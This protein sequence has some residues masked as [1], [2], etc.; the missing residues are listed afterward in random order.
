MQPR[1]TDGCASCEL[2]NSREH[3]AAH[4][5]SCAVH[6]L[7]SCAYHPCGYWKCWGTMKGFGAGERRYQSWGHMDY[8]ARIPCIQTPISLGWSPLW[9]L[10]QLKH[11]KCSLSLIALVFLR[12]AGAGPICQGPCY[13]LGP[14]NSRSSLITQQLRRKARRRNPA[15]LLIFTLF[16]MEAEVASVRSEVIFRTV[17]LHHQLLGSASLFEKWKGLLPFFLCLLEKQVREKNIVMISQ[18]MHR[19]SSIPIIIIKHQE[20]MN[21]VRRPYRA[22]LKPLA[23]LKIFPDI[24]LTT[25]QMAKFEL[26]QQFADLSP[27][28]V[29]FISKPSPQTPYFVRLY[30]LNCI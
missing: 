16:L 18:G 8:E 7:C 23:N 30:S 24:S 5:P 10:W 21:R 6:Q 19:H 26:D 22:A 17:S 1:L 3:H 9:R 20:V 25:Y 4:N 27:L 13:F 29:C 14:Y 28:R 2:H 15:T 12:F 11:P